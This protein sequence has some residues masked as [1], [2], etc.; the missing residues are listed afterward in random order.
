MGD[1]ARSLPLGY[2]TYIPTAI[3]IVA[4]NTVRTTIALLEQ[5]GMRASMSRGG[6]C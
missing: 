4:A 5:F 1:G 3:R 2:I 6:N